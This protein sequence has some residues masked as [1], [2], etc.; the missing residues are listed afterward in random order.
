MNES[1]VDVDLICKNCQHQISLHKPNCT[2]LLD[3]NDDRS[4]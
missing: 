3:S 2:T 1:E 4:Y